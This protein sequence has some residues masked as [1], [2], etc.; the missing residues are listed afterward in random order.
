MIKIN[1]NLFAFVL[2]I[3]SLSLFLMTFTRRINNYFINT[4]EIH[5]LNFILFLSLLTFLIAITGLKNLNSWRAFT[6][7]IITFV[8]TI[9]IS[10]VCIFILIIGNILS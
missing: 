2:S 10:C 6:R 5:P 7:F 9:I 4:F 8:I 1:V 3:F